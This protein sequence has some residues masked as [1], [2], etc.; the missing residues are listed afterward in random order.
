MGAAV[1]SGFLGVP[2]VAYGH[3]GRTPPVA[4]DFAAQITRSVQRIRTKVVDGDQTLWLDAGDHTVAV[5]GIQ[6]EPLL[7]FDS[8]GVWLNVHSVTAQIDQID[9]FDLHPAADPHARPLWRRLSSAHTFEW[10]EH[11]LH[12]LEPLARG[13]TRP[14]VL[15]TWSIPIVVDGRPE[16]LAG[17]LRYDPPPSLFLWLGIISLLAALGALAALRSSG[18]VVAF[19]LAAVLIVW[20]LRVA[21]ELYG[22]PAVGASGWVDVAVT[23]VVGLTLLYGLVRTD[24]GVRLFVAFLVAFGSL[25][26]GLATYPVLTRRTALTLLPTEEARVAVALTLILGAA[27]LTGS[28]KQLA[29][30][31]AAQGENGRRFEDD[32]TSA[33]TRPAQGLRMS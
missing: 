28:W 27:V 19:A 26:Q 20:S 32:D 22:R 5:R 3:V 4:T 30:R 7:F 14:T 33:P 24:F 10:H 6:G 23:S 2:S 31:D 1:L 17:V 9:R 15:G 11:R 13:R 25:Y 12:L 29:R 16:P 21:R 8:R 18:A